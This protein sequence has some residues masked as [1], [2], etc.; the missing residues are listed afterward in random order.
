MFQ[1]P[2][3]PTSSKNNGEVPESGALVQRWENFVLRTTL[4]ALANLL[5]Q[6]FTRDLGVSKVD[7]AVPP[8]H[9]SAGIIANRRR[10]GCRIAGDVLIEY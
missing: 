3:W 10:H 6:V 5:R 9:H 4:C 1:I 2:A 8:E 7:G